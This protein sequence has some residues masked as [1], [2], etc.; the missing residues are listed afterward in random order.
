M[1]ILIIFKPNTNNHI[2]YL[3]SGVKYFYINGIS[4]IFFLLGI[5]LLYGNGYDLNLTELHNQL[6]NSILT[7][8]TL[9]ITSNTLFAILCIFLS[10]FLNVNFLKL[11]WSYFKVLL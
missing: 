5:C 2:Y 6:L 8:K 10:L 3:K 4:G 7:I 9:K 11:F 1:Y